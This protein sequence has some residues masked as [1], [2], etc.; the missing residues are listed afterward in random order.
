MYSTINIINIGVYYIQKLLR[1]YIL[2][3]QEKKNSTTLILYL[4]EMTGDH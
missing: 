1:E 3:V 4:Y 2:R